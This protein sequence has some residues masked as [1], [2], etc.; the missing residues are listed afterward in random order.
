[1]SHG[2]GEYIVIGK[3]GAVYGIKGWLKIH[4]L[5]EQ[6]TDLLQYKPLYLAQGQTWEPVQ[7]ETGRQHGKGLVAKLAGVDTP[8]AA[9]LLTGKEMA[10][11]REQLPPL[12]ENEFYWADL[13]GLTVIDQRGVALGKV[14]YLIATGSNDVLVIRTEQ[15]KEHGI[16]YLPER[17][18][19]KIDLKQGIILVEWELI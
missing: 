16:P 1:M 14:I 3:V 8:E 18:I 6:V 5:T 7:I 17:V 4:S 2:T 9:R 15:G 19:K 12:P 13:E 10:I 11:K